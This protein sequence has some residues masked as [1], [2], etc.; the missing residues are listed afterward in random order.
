MLHPTFPIETGRLV[1]R[2]YVDGDAEALYGIQRRPDVTR[3][4]YW[5]PRSKA[6]V[7][8]MIERRK[9]LTQLEREGDGLLLAAVLRTS[10]ALIGDVSLTWSS[11][12]HRQGE[13]GY[14]LHPDYQGHGYAT[15]M[16]E[17]MLRLGFAGLELHRIIGRCDAR[18]RASARVMERL[19]MRREAHLVENEFV[20]GEWT[21]E[22]V[23][24]I[25]AVEWAARGAAR[26]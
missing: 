18:N 12:E 10:G 22:Y 8:R 26:A 9:T 1:L 13:V 2:P 3:Y 24:A 6:D 15:E 14:V 5:Q 16:T 19:G 7:R 25:L 21:S 23:Y 4:L 17:L 11:E 20:K